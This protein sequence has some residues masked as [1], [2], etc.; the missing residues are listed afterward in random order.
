MKMESFLERGLSLF[1]MECRAV[2]LIGNDEIALVFGMIV[3]E[4]DR[5]TRDLEILSQNHIEAVFLLLVRG[6]LAFI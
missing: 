2:R 5:G 6:R 3:R 4:G 1:S